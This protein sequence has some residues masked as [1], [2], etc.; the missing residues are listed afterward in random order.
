MKKFLISLIN[1]HS[2]NR[3]HARNIGRFMDSDRFDALPL[4]ERKL[5]AKQ[6]AAMQELDTILTE[7]LRIHGIEV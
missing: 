4:A 7:R 1:Q 6:Y 2:R 5:L 3:T